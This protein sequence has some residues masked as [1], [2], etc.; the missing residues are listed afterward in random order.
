MAT[1]LPDLTHEHHERLMSHVDRMPALGDLVGTS[2]TDALRAHLDELVPFLIGTLVPHV[3]AAE[4][5]LYPEL[6]RLQ[7]NAHSMTPMRRE[8][9]RI[10][11]L[12]D[13]L[14]GLR[15]KLDVDA[16]GIRD[17]VAL[18]RSVFGLYA[19]L[20]VHLAEEELYMHI[21]E[22]G[23]SADAAKALAAAMEHPVAAA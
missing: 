22:R 2:A 10:R 14:A 13:D 20:K 16:P 7:Q 8:H 12:V 6:E 4:Q 11:H 17:T 18:R 19:L 3:D 9:A 1:T 15:R 5:T 23:V 21:V